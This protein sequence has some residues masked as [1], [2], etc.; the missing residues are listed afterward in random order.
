M[1]RFVLTGTPGAGKST[2]LRQL[3]L[4]GFAVVEEAATDLIAVAQAQGITEPW[5]H[6]WF[7]DAIVD[8]QKRRQMR[9]SCLADEVQ[10]YDRSVFCT[11]ALAVYLG[12]QRSL[13]LSRELERVERHQIYE[14]R[15]F[16]VRHLGFITP[17]GARRISLEEAL[18]FEQIHEHLYRGFGFELISVEP[19]SVAD[20][21]ALIKAAL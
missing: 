14:K 15:V 3:E 12:Q 20:R 2:I 5:R 10:F 19:G 1:R 17:T 16:F 11:A 6:A 4:E 18:R 7:I 9:A 21:V 8:L 13:A